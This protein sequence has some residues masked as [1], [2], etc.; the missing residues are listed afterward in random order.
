MHPGL[1][2]T[3]GA[4]PSHG[5]DQAGLVHPWLAFAALPTGLKSGGKAPLAP[6]G[7]LLSGEGPGYEQADPTLHKRRWGRGGE[8]VLA[9]GW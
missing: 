9:L 6:H 8:Q 5:I 3:S 2:R 1:G 4:S 7:D